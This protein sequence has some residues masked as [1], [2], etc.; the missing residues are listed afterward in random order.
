MM[1][2]GATRSSLIGVSLDYGTSGNRSNRTSRDLLVEIRVWSRLSSLQRFHV[3]RTRFWKPAPASSPLSHN[4]TFFAFS[5]GIK[6]LNSI[7]PR[8]HPVHFLNF[9]LVKRDGNHC[10]QDSS[11]GKFPRNLA[12]QLNHSFTYLKLLPK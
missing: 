3:G 10:K 6:R 1:R 8:D 7:I 4:R 12:P 9:T 5:G 2:V 11:S